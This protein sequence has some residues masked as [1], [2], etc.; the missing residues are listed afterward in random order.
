MAIDRIHGFIVYLCDGCGEELETDEREWDDAFAVLKQEKW[1]S[2]KSADD[3][4]H[5]CGYACKREHAS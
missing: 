4:R 3:W 2:V 1:L 5:Y